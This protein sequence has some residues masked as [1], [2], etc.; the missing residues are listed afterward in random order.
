MSEKPVNAEGAASWG[1][2]FRLHAAEKWRKPSGVLG[3]A[4]TETFVAFAAPKPGMQILDVATGTGEPAITLAGLVGPT[5]KVVAFDQSSDLLEVARKRAAERSLTSLETRCG[6]AH[7]L[8]FPD[9]SFDLA[10]CRH[11]VMFFR[12]VVAALRELRRVLKPG[13]RACFL[14]WGP[15]EQPYWQSMIGVVHRHAGGPLLPEGGDNP[16]RFGDPGSLSRALRDAGFSNVEEETRNIPWS[17][18]GSPEDVWEYARAVAAPFKPLLARVPE[19]MWP[20]IH[21]DA[22]TE[23]RRLY[24]GTSVNFGATM[25][26]AAGNKD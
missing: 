22:L 8:P 26:L 16:F 1:S 12:D 3:K 9:S 13:A 11:G 25:V 10:T 15:F 5:G 18:P 24:D 4:A 21:A 7:H 23:L 17:W 6:D 14:C 2:A 19:E 20:A